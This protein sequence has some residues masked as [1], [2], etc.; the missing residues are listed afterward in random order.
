LLSIELNGDYDAA[1][2]L[3]VNFGLVPGEVRGKLEEMAN[4][5]VDILPHYTI[6][7]IPKT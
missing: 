3:I 2:R 6:R 7:A 1:G 4:L 5:P